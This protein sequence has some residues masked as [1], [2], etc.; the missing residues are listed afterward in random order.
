MAPTRIII[1]DDHVL[2]RESLRD[3]LDIMESGFSIVEAGTL[4]E[5][6]VAAALGPPPDMI[7]LDL[8]M[9]GMNG[10][11]GLEKMLSKNS[12]V[13]IAILS[14]TIDK[15]IMRQALQLGSKGFIPKTISGKAMLNAIRLILSGDMYVPPMLLSAGGLDTETPT[16]ED[17][18][19]DGIF[20][21]LTKREKE[22]LKS[23]S[24]GHPNKIIARELDC[25]EVTVK[26]HLKSIFRKL[27]VSNRTQAVTKTM[28]FNL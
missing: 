25:Q 3:S 12:G 20:D 17:S 22:V 7:I 19:K 21:A 15:K 28:E 5:A 14:G 1:A 2:L 16:E 24:K 4:E 8:D 26:A 11:S 9:P 13:P 10:L 6:E 27:G 23:L 18:E